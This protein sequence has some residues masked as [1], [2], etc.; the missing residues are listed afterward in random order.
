[1][2]KEETMLKKR[3]DCNSINSVD[4][5]LAASSGDCP[6]SERSAANNIMPRKLESKIVA[7][8]QNMGMIVKDGS[9]TRHEIEM[10]FKNQGKE[11]ALYINRKSYWRK[12]LLKIALRPA[13]SERIAQQILDF[14]CAYPL[15]LKDDQR[16]SYSSNYKA[17][18]N[19][20]F[21]KGIKNEHFGWAWIVDVEGDFSK[22]E[23]FLDTA[24]KSSTATPF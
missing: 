22:L 19:K 3:T 13:F 1:M 23:L 24:C 14:D 7:I 15:I 4:L 8:A 6:P 9:E 2:G 17:F 11:E 18:N 12:G 20:R 5:Q 21:A 10:R 16:K